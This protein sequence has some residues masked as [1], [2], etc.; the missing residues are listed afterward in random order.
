MRVVGDRL[1]RLD[2]A[3]VLE[4]RSIGR[5][6]AVVNRVLEA[7]GERIHAQLLRQFVHGALDGKGRDRCAG[8]AIGG[9][10]GR[11][12]DDIEAGDQEVRDVVAGERGHGARANRRAGEGA[13]LVLEQDIGGDDRAVRLRAQLD[14]HDG[15][16]G[17]TGGAEDLV[18]RHH[19]LHRRTGLLRQG[20]GHR[21]DIDRGLAAK[22]AADLGR[23]DPDVRCL[24][25]QN[26]GAIGAD[27]ELALAGGP[28][29][30]LAVGAEAGDAGVRLDIAL[31]NGRRDVAAFDDHVRRG[32][33][34]GKVAA[35]QLH[36]RGDVGGFIGLGLKA[37]GEARF[38]QQR[39]VRGHGRLDIGDMR[40]HFILHIDQGKRS[41]GDRRRDR[42]HRGHG[43]ALVEHLVAG[44]AVE[45]NIA[46]VRCT[47]T[48]GEFLGSL[49]REIR[50][51]DDRF[52]AGKRARLAGIDRDDAR[53]GMRAAQDLADQ[54]A[55]HGEV[56]AVGRPSGNL[57][58][59]IGTR[60]AR[61]HNS[62]GIA[63]LGTIANVGH[64]TLAC[65]I[66][67][68]ASITARITLS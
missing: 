1:Q 18:T 15:A 12:V 47:L 40:Q 6:V 41:I 50:A 30:A 66:S 60:R 28:D 67:A 24:D 42:R 36:A 64:A 57:V 39:R 34:A 54:L 3:D 29:L 23:G 14:L 20:Q 46:N 62:K 5:L 37:G 52:H 10:L 38:V 61:A 48:A 19:D 2:I 25:V 11:V 43:V 32:E 17:R 51:D 59:T 58:D 44:H 55:R 16:G 68:P 8:R 26:L 65:L 27:H 63:R 7:Q 31:V 13:G 45:G 49:I 22:S 33:A 53:M 9:D 35:L 4:G 56:R 21:L